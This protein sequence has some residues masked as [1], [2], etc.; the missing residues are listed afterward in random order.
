MTKSNLTTLASAAK[1]EEPTLA[2]PSPEPG[3]PPIP[4]DAN[5]RFL[6]GSPG[7][8]PGSR[9]LLAG[10]VKRELLKEFL[11]ERGELMPR[12]KRWFLPQYMQMIT[13]LASR[14]DEAEAA[15][16]AE[17]IAALKQALAAA[18]AAAAQGGSR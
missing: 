11:A 1:V 2:E 17:E 10:Q 15:T 14:G 8:R 6:P 4:R 12:F 18:E 16:P 7:R 5:G 3:Y 9:N 13:R